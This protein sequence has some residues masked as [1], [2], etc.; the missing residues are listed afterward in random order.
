MKKLGDVLSQIDKDLFIP[1]VFFLSDG[2]GEKRS[3][4]LKCCKNVYQDFST[5]DVLFFSVGYGD[6]PGKD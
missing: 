3:D 1:I 2:Y 6:A 4:V 5:I